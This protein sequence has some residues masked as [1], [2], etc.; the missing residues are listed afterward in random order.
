[1][2]T[3]FAPPSMCP[4]TVPL[5]VAVPPVANVAFGISLACLFFHP[6][7]NGATMRADTDSSALD[8]QAVERE[9]KE[10][11]VERTSKRSVTYR[12]SPLSDA[13]R[14]YRPDPET[15]HSEAEALLHCGL[16][17]LGKS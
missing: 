6:L 8:V 2:A 14:S 13:V 12:Q 11:L 16:W 10:S 4:F 9:G 7:L 15:E 17:L 3:C 1:M 5:A